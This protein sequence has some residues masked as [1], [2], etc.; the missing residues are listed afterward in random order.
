MELKCALLICMYSGCCTETA[1]EFCYQFVGDGLSCMICQR[2]RLGPFW[3]YNLQ[4][5]LGID[6]HYLWLVDHPQSDGM[7]ERFNRTLEQMLSMFVDENRDDLPFLTMAYRAC[8]YDRTHCTPNLPMLGTEILLPIDISCA[9][10]KAL[11]IASRIHS[12]YLI[13]QVTSL[14]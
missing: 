14:W 12:T 6:F 11:C 7:V 13:G 2:V 9:I 3:K 10:S 8:T 1:Y 4:L 5:P